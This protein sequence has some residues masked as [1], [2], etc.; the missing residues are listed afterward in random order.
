MQPVAFSL[1]QVA[2]VASD[3]LDLDEVVL[4]GPYWV[5]LAAWM[6]PLVQR[7]V[8]ELTVLRSVRPVRVRSSIR[9]DDV[10]AVGAASLAMETFFLAS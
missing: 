3:L 9:A 4:G 5:E 6:T 10:G 2:S 8:D 1:A 7:S